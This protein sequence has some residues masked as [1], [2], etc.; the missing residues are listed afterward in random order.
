MNSKSKKKSLDEGRFAEI[1]DGWIVL[2]DIDRQEGRG[3]GV[4]R[5]DRTPTTI[6]V[7]GSNIDLDLFPLKVEHS[8]DGTVIVI[9]RH[10]LAPRRMSVGQNVLRRDQATREKIVL[11][12]DDLSDKES[13]RRWQYVL[14]GLR[15][16]K[17]LVDVSVHRRLP[18]N[19]KKIFMDF[20]AGLSNGIDVDSALGPLYEK[21]GTDLTNEFVA[22]VNIYSRGERINDKPVFIL[23]DKAGNYTPLAVYG[24]L[25]EIDRAKLPA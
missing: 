2:Y 24:K 9:P 10:G 5:V 3:W 15:D 1:E 11:G 12:D 16:Q 7:A 14:Q 20:A 8:Y 6:R 18:K 17:R 25:P 21:Y 23:T 13:E 4:I 22:A 19:A